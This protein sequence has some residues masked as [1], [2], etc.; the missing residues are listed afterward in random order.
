MAEISESEDQ[1]RGHDHHHHQ[2]VRMFDTKGEQ[3]GS[4]FLLPRC[5]LCRNVSIRG[6]L[7]AGG[8]K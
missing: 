4:P 3:D 1:G 2:Y 7:R 6:R 5:V 8:V